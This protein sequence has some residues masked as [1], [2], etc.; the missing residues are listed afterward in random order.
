[1]SPIP[2]TVANFH[3][4]DKCSVINCNR[5]HTLYNKDASSPDTCVFHECCDNL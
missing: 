1:M 3:Y 4:P 2:T 5:T